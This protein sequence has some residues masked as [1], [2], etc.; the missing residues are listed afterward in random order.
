[1]HTKTP[2]TQINQILNFSTS[3]VHNILSGLCIGCDLI[4]PAEGTGPDERLYDVIERE[5]VLAPAQPS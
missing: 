4:Y 1:M 3:E 2:Q 5:T